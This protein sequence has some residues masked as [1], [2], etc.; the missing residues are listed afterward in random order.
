MVAWGRKY[1][2]SGRETVCMN[3]QRSRRAGTAGDYIQSACCRNTVAQSWLEKKGTIEEAMLSFSR[4]APMDVCQEKRT[5]ATESLKKLDS[6]DRIHS[7]I[8]FLVS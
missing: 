5:V 6:G 2:G 8:G 7:E 3:L 1:V 4:T